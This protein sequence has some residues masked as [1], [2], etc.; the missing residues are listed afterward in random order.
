METAEGTFVIDEWITAD[1]DAPEGHSS[2]TAVVRK[3]F[4]GGIEGSSQANLVL[5]QTPVEGSMAY[6]G[7]ERL[8]VAIDGRRGS[9]LLMH[10]ALSVRGEATASWTTCRTRGPAG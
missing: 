5:A 8:N 9:F 6:V 1:V 2:S 10:S 7:L 3:T 4:S